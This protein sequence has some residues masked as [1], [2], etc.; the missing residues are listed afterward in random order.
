[1]WDEVIFRRL[2]TRERLGFKL[3]YQPG[4]NFCSTFASI[5]SNFFLIPETEVIALDGEWQVLL[6]ANSLKE[7]HSKGDYKESDSEV[8]VDVKPS[9][10]FSGNTSSWLI[11]RDF[12]GI[13]HRSLQ[14]FQ[15]LI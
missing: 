9:R 12:R 6:Y 5:C 10:T 3:Y 4:C 8:V 11:V 14:F 7:V 13:T 1:V 15:A 2:R